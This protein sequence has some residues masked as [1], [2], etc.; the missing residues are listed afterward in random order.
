MFSLSKVSSNEEYKDLVTAICGDNEELIK[1]NQLAI[2]DARGFLRFYVRLKQNSADPKKFATYKKGLE[3]TLKMEVANPIEYS[4]AQTLKALERFDYYMQQR[5]I[6]FVDSIK[7]LIKKNP[8]LILGGLHVQDLVQQ[9]KAEGIQTEV[10]TP[11][12]YTLS[13][14][15]L[16]EDLKSELEKQ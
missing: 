13:S 9:L 3:E 10:I 8:I 15:K 7:K 12:G 6:S 4:K 16:A 5:N 14:E 2:S 11:L 1:K